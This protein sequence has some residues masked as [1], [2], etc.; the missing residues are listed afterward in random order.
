M[1][2]YG[3]PEGVPLQNHHLQD[4]S[5]LDATIASPRS[6]HRMRLGVEDYSVKVERRLWRIQQIQVLQRL[7][8]EEALHIVALLFGLDIEQRGEADICLAVL[9]Q[10]VGEGL[11]HFEISRL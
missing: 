11:A 2:S 5:V 9:L 10:A 4:H 3:T 8:Q 6:L 7:R 1:L